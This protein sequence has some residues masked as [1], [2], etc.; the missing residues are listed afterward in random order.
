[1]QRAALLRDRAVLTALT[2]GRV[3]VADDAVVVLVAVSVHELRFPG[4]RCSQIGEADCWEFRHE[5][6]T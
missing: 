2:L 5:M 6:G 3:N 1:M 4:T